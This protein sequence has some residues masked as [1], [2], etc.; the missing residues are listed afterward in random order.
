MRDLLVT[1]IVFGAVPLILMR[2]WL[3]ILMW[4]WLGYMNPHRLSWGF[5]YDFPFAEVTAL[6]TLAGFVFTRERRGLPLSAI[7]VTWF[8]FVLWMTLTT[9]VALDPAEGWPAWQSVMKI[10]L[11]TVLTVFLVRTPERLRALVWVIA[12]S[13]GFYGVKGGLFVLRA[14][15]EWQVW[16]P[17]GSFIADNNALALAIIMTLP[18][19]W[20]LWRATPHRTIRWGLALAMVLSCASILGSHSRGAALAG[21]VMIGLLWLKSSGK[22]LTGL[23][24]AVL[25]PVLVLSMPEKWFERMETVTTYQ[26]DGS[27]M[28]RVRAW[29]FAMDMASE[30]FPGG[31]FGSFSEKNYRRYSPAIAAQVDE[32]GLGRFQDAHSIYFKVLGEHGWVGLGL[33]LA[34]GLLSYLGAGAI[35][36]D[37]RE[38]PHLQWAGSLAA[39]LQVSMVGFAVGG[40]FL[41]LSYFDLYYHLVAIVIVLR[42]MIVDDVAAHAETALSPARGA[43]AGTDARLAAPDA[44]PTI[45][46]AAPGRDG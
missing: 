43:L 24:I 27:A 39:M 26:Q 1:L 16:G 44:T 6:A 21:A 32:Y 5:A 11:F 23:A 41:G 34:L 15:G 28:G 12:L 22:L 14:G 33:F 3:G 30:R 13:L 29:E 18:L 46:S 35:V 42:A 38:L 17:P 37:V 45:A 40:A 2:P 25:L 31:G 7:T 9:L 19:L 36:R 8:L 20:F 4:S 10:Q